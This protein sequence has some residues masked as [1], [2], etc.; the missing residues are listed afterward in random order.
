M[1]EMLETTQKEWIIVQNGTKTE[2][3]HIIPESGTQKKKEFLFLGLYLFAS[4]S[5]T[6]VSPYQNYKINKVEPRHWL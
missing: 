4:I 6:H 3:L 2:I 5:I 1:S